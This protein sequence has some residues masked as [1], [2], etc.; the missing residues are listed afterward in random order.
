MLRNVSMYARAS[1]FNSQLLDILATPM[2]IPSMVAKITPRTDALTVF[3]SAT[4]RA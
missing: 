3:S 1:R 4:P 2:I